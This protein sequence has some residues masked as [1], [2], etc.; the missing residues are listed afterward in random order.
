[1]ITLPGILAF[2]TELVSLYLLARWGWQAGGWWLAVA[3]P[4]AFIAVW[5]PLLSPNA[6]YRLALHP[7][8][9]LKL[10]LFA[11]VGLAA[12]RVWGAAPAIALS[13]LNAV[14]VL[15]WEPPT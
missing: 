2:A 15:A 12:T 1:M 8:Q 5:G 14:I 13:A 11:V 9:A 10:G 7:R 6:A 4:A 3:A